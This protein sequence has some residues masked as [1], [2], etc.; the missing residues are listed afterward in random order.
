M[1]KKIGKVTINKN[2]ESQN[3]APPG[4]FITE[5]FPVFSAFPSPKIDIEQWALSIKQENELLYEFNWEEINSM[6]TSIIKED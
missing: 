1:Q 4:Q 2:L 5:K 6:K 3:D